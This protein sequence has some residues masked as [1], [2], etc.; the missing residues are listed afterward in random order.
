MISRRCEEDEERNYIIIMM[1]KMPAI[2]NRE[3]NEGQIGE[4]RG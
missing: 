2:T 4:E 3:Q 1:N